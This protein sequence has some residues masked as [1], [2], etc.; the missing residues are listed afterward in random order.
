MSAFYGLTINNEMAVNR[1]INAA[2]AVSLGNIETNF[3]PQVYGD[4]FGYYSEKVMGAYFFL[5]SGNREKNITAPSHSSRFDVDE[6]VI[7]LGA[8]IILELA[9]QA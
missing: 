2:K 8:A 6:E 1:V 5:G 3:L 9:L 7:A 4:D